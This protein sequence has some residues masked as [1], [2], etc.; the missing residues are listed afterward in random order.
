M[1]VIE[2]VIGGDKISLDHYSMFSKFQDV[3]RETT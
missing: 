1:F 2:V 3:P